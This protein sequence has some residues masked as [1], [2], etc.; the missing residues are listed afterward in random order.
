MIH[1]EGIQQI[2]LISNIF[3]MIIRLHLFIEVDMCYIF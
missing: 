1:R 3:I 2:L